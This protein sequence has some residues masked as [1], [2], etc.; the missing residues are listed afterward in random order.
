MFQ[1][2]LYGVCANNKYYMGNQSGWEI[3]SFSEVV[4]D[5]TEK[6]PLEQNLGREGRKSLTYLRG[7]YYRNRGASEKTE[8]VELVHLK[9]K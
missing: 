3:H 7:R 6:V 5:I 9:Q 1:N 4:R 8:N 2:K